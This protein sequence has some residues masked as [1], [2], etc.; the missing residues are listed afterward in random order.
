MQPL[1][2]YW[3]LNNPNSHEPQEWKHQVLAVEESGYI[4]VNYA[5]IGATLKDDLL[6][7]KEAKGVS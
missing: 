2:N 3:L 5:M 6:S 7:A 4:T 1:I